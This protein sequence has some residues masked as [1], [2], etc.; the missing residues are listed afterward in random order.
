MIAVGIDVSKYK[1]TVAIISNTGEILLPP[2]VYTHTYSALLSLVSL[3]KKQ[4]DDIRIVMEAT[5]HYHYPILKLLLGHHFFV[6]VVNPYII[7]KYNDN[8]LRKVKTDKQDAIRLAF[9]AL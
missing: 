3:Q 1:S 4:N 8:N 2:K 9:Y 6:S 7:K 5:G